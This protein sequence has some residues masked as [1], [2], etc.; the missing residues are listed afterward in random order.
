MCL[1]VKLYL[2]EVEDLIRLTAVFQSLS[3]VLHSCLLRHRLT[4]YHFTDS[5]NV[6]SLMKVSEEDFLLL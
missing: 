6:S 5:A 2:Y 3:F 1:L 4:G